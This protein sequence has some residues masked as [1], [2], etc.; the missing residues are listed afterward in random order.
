MKACCFKTVLSKQ[1]NKIMKKKDKKPS[2]LVYLFGKTWKYSEGNRKNVVLYWIMFIVANTLNLVGEPF[3]IA[4]LINEVQEN[5]ISGDNI[6][7]LFMLLGILV[8]I[9]FV[10]WAIHGPA[11][12]IERE[13]AFKVRYNYRHF[14]LKG[15]MTM[16]MDWHT[17]HHSGDTIDKVGKGT[18]GLYSFA[19]DSFHVIYSGVRLLVCLSVL[20]YFSYFTALIVLAMLLVSALITMK[21]DK[22]ISDQ[23]KELNLSENKISESV[24]DAISN[25]STV[26]ILRVEKLVFDAIMK[27]TE[28]PFPLFRKNQYTI[29]IKWF[30]VSMCCQIMFAIALGAYLYQNINAEGA[31]L[32]G[33]LFLVVRYL[34]QIGEL[35]FTFTMMYGEIVR[36]VNH[37][38]N[39]EMLSEDFK[40][41]SFTNHVLPKGWKNLEVRDLDFAYQGVDEGVMHLNGINMQFSKGEKIAVVGESGSGKSTFLKLIR[42]LY[43]PTKGNLLCDG[44]EISEGFSGIS[45][46][47]ALVPQNPEI[48]A[49]TIRENITLGA[50]YD[51]KFVRK[52]TDMACFTDVVSGLP[53]GLDSSIKEKGV[54]LSGGQQQRLALARGL[55]ACDDK[56]IVLLDEPTSSLDT[57]TERRVYQN[58]FQSFVG[59][60]IFSSIHRLHLLPLFDTIHVFSNGKIIAS[61][62][63]NQLLQSCPEF[64]ELW[65]LYS[66]SSVS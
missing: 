53:K 3:L 34:S 61:G 65:N 13:N 55:L 39:S 5:G 17:E 14:L 58:I 10:F 44:K 21:F 37:L 59:K 60:T 56:D 51:P 4:R 36:Q 19:E 20:A 2:S 64:V 16:P 49:T 57:A 66:E 26:I 9:E 62:S 30:L 40:S 6:N 43:H 25:I 54:N 7:F 32:M 47:I 33:S 46:A 63:L 18:T 12:C 22:I 27:K 35:F 24:F 31:I 48:F 8:L 15:V 42:D 41:E 29:E 45:R 23:Y 52:F 11:R 1:K 38:F 28:E 50:E